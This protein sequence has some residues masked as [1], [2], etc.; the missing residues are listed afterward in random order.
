MTDSSLA[1]KR[2]KVTYT[3]S[4]QGIERAEKALKRLGFES[5][6]NFAQSQLL[7]RST[8]T[9]FF[10]CQ[11]IQLDSFKRI[12]K[13]LTLNWAEVARIIEEGQSQGLE[14]N[15]YSS[16]DTDEVVQ[17]QAVHR[18]VTVVDKQSKKIK[19]VIV[20]EGDINSVNSDLK[21]SLELA[22][23]TY[24]GDTIKITDIQAGSIRLIV[25]GSQEDIEWLVSRIQSGGLTE[26]SGFPVE[27]IQILNES[28]D[29]EENDELNDKWHLV[30]EI[31]NHAVEGRNLRNADLSD[32]DLI[33]V[34][35]SGADLSGADLSGADLIGANLIIANLSGA[36]LSGADLIG[37]DLIGANLSGVNLIGADLI[38]ANLS[39]ANLIGADLIGANL[40]GA[41]LS[42]ANLISTD[43]SHAYLGG[44]KLRDANLRGANL[45]GANLIGANLS[46]ANL[47]DVNLSDVNVKNARFGNNQGISEAIKRDLIQKGAIFA[48]SPGDRSSILLS[49]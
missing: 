4:T 20:L 46:G 13:A 33:G 32:A 26:L 27:D 25:E 19:A 15:N 43:L 28:L 9:K 49:G 11:P 35:L 1:R 31:V 41:K 8:V 6:S 30:Q 38:G 45:M 48:D 34:N 36:K 44:A 7:S 2:K 12:C 22:L 14:R 17:V 16:P 47:S 37:A 18:Q 10:Q 24:P 40:S 21:V 29:D 42:G 23:L 3:A 5:K 39:G